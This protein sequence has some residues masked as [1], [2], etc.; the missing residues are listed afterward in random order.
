MK[1]Q[2]TVSVVM[3]T[4]NGERFL[5]EQMDSI[6]AQTY[7][8]KE[9]I[10]QDDRSTDGTAGIMH[11]YMESH[12]NIRLF[13]N[14]RNLGYNQNFETAV[15]H[16][17]GDFVALADQDDV[18]FPRKIE[19]LVEGIGEHSICF[20]DVL[21]GS[22]RGTSKPTNYKYGLEALLFRPFV[23]HAM[24]LKRGFAQDEKSWKLWRIY[25]WSIELAAHVYGNGI[26]KTGEPLVWHRTHEGEVTAPKHAGGA[27]PK[28]WHPYVYGWKIYRRLQKNAYWQETYS[29]INKLCEKNSLAN[30]ITGCLLNRKTTSLLR[31]CFLCMAHKEKVYP[32]NATGLKGCLRGLFFPSIYAFFNKGEFV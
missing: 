31:L 26:A 21:R 5:R 23:G 1:Q 19:R 12:E 15:M 27:K 6:L 14:E 17:T 29:R 18:W 8:I 24:L 4:Y 13:Q 10:V 28:V 9:I 32:G 11:E 20:S 2:P 16:A 22:E 25:D 7:P 30:K 3:A